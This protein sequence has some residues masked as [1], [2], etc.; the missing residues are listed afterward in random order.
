MTENEQLAASVHVC[1]LEMSCKSLCRKSYSFQMSAHSFFYFFFSVWIEIMDDCSTNCNGNGECISGHCHCFPGFLGPDCAKGN[2]LYIHSKYM[3]TALDYELSTYIGCHTDITRALKPFF[4]PEHTQHRNTHCNF[5][6]L[7]PLWSALPSFLPP[8]P[9][10][11]CTRTHKYKYVIPRI[12]CFSH[13]CL[14]AGHSV[15][16][17]LSFLSRIRFSI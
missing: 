14:F 8:F 3:T 11:T 12:H 6:Q 17:G 10:N 1:F 9:P 13:A 4:Q 2:L 7:Q 15:M 16:E 5:L